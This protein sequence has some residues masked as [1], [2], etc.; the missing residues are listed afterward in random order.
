MCECA[1]A[2]SSVC[3]FMC[4]CV[5]VCV[6]THE[7]TMT[8]TS[9]CLSHRSVAWSRAFGP[10]TGPIFMDDVNCTG[11]ENRL[12]QCEFPGFGQ[13]NCGHGED[14]GA[15]CNVTCEFVFTVCLQ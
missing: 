8:S 15:H 6:P 12:V 3:M 11:Q 1:R 7:G 13:H 5:C 14:F 4:V 2:C 9:P 10:G